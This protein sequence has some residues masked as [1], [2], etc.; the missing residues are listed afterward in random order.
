[1]GGLFAL[2]VGIL[3][4]QMCGVISLPR[5]LMPRRRPQSHW[6]IGA[7]GWAS[8]YKKGCLHS[9]SFVFAI[10]QFRIFDLS[11]LAFQKT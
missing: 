6:M 3:L 4:G 7:H 11:M 10:L 2:H 8:K 1:V 5:K 9:A